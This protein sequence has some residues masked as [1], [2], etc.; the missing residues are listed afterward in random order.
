MCLL[1]LSM[2]KSD[3]LKQLQEI[4]THLSCILNQVQEIKKALNSE[5]EPTK[6]RNLRNERMAYYAALYHA[7]FERD[8]KAHPH[9]ERLQKQFKLKKPPPSKRVL[10]YLET[11]DPKAFDGLK[12]EWEESLLNCNFSIFFFILSNN[13]IYRLIDN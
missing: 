8:A 6:R 1:S 2:D 5:K 12:R 11:N 9:K 7:K 13:L 10:L 4:E 3:M